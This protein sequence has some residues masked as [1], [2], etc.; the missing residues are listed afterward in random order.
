MKFNYFFDVLLS[1]QRKCGSCVF[2]TDSKQHKLHKLDMTTLKNHAQR[3]YMIWLPRIL[4]WLLYNLQLDDFPGADFENSLYAFGQSEKRE[5]VECK[6]ISKTTLWKVQNFSVCEWK[7]ELCKSIH[8]CDENKFFI[9]L[10]LKA[11]R[12]SI[13]GQLEQWSLWEVSKKPGLGMPNLLQT[14]FQLKSLDLH[15][16]WFHQI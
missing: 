16:L 10:V 14:I 12:L 4:T 13:A 7:C 1:H 3:S 2:M 5:W 6:I 9:T 15:C 11:N 8:K